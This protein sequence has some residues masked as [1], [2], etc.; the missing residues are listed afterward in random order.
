MPETKGAEEYPSLVKA[1]IF[2]EVPKLREAVAAI[3]D[4]RIVKQQLAADG[5]PAWAVPH[6]PE[7]HNIVLLEAA[8]PTRS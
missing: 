5:R 1:V 8:Q 7:G 6:D 4:G 2:L 3:G